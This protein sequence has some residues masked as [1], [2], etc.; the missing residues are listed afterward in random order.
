[1]NDS[2]EVSLWLRG[3][4]GDNCEQKRQAMV[5]AVLV[6]QNRSVE[7]QKASK[8][9]TN[10]VYGV[11]FSIGIC[12]ESVERLKAFDD[13]KVIALV[14]STRKYII[15]R[16][17]LIF[18]LRMSGGSSDPDQIELRLSAT[19]R[20]IFQ[21]VGQIYTPRDVQLTLPY[22]DWQTDDVR[23]VEDFPFNIDRIVCVACDASADGG[24]QHVYIGEAGLEI[25]DKEK[26]RLK[27]KHREGLPLHL[28]HGES[29]SLAGVDSYLGH[30]DDAPIPESDLSLRQPDQPAEHEIDPQPGT[31][32]G[33]E[34]VGDA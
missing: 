17:A 4:L 8:I 3:T 16:G 11:S 10:H 26:G 23:S 25:I 21:S 32:M 18:P 34:Q 1:M 27:W 15:L 20:A 19:R 9:N 6:T 29:A 30:F 12:K 7:A 13:C 14:G 24:I 31:A 22:A 33:E 2:A 28:I 5:N